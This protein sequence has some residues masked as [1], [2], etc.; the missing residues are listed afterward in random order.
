MA[1]VSTYIKHYALELLCYND[2]C[3]LNWSQTGVFLL[4]GVKMS[5][6]KRIYPPLCQHSAF[7]AADIQKY[8]GSKS[9]GVTDNA[10]E[11]SVPFSCTSFSCLALLRLPHELVSTGHRVSVLTC[12]NKWEYCGCESLKSV[13]CI[14]ESVWKVSHLIGTTRK[15]YSIQLVCCHFSLWKPYIPNWYEKT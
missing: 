14:D 10:D 2:G 8:F 3:V 12:H 1:V 7:F 4:W 9:T 11:G 6:V 15:N 5:A 13:L